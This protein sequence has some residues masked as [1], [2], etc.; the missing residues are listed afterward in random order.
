M[1]IMFFIAH[2][3][4]SNPDM[5]IKKPDILESISGHPCLNQLNSN[6]FKKIQFKCGYSIIFSV[7]KYREAHNNVFKNE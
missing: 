3:L 1:E 7:V 6:Q 5:L 4:F 2:V